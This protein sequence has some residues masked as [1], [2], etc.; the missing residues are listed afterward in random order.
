MQVSNS[1]AGLYGLLGNGV[2]GNIVVRAK[3]AGSAAIASA[4]SGLSSATTGTDSEATKTFLDYMK[5]S[6]A[7]HLRDAWLKSHNL[8]EEKLAA[9]SPA[10]RAAVEKQIADDIKKQ[11]QEEAAKK[12]TA[13]GL[14][15]LLNRAAL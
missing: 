15:G 14:T 10:E 3:P 6:A 11:M 9:M 13:K 1:I 5:K 7:Q 4:D 2:Q 12:V 8:T